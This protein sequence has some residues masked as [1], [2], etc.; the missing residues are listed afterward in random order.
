MQ[1][2]P[3]TATKQLLVEGADAARF[4]QAFLAALD[5]SGWQVHNF[6]GNSELPGFL[7][8]VALMSGFND[9]ASL[10]IIRDAETDPQAAFQSVCAALRKASLAAPG[11]SSAFSSGR[12]Q[13]GVFIL[14]D[15]SSAGMLES[16]CLRAVATDRPSPVLKRISSAWRGPVCS[17]QSTWKRRGSRR[18]W[19]PVPGPACASE[20]P[21]RPASGRGRTPPSTRCETF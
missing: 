20:R 15:S 18:F 8:A 7:K 6:G 17:G 16:I 10:A 21:P 9:I 1:P 4:F 14:P 19:H 13:V 5:L 3:L 11:K 12:P 2:Q